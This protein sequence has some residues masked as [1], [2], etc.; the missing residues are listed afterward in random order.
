M[1]SNEPMWPKRHICVS[2]SEASGLTELKSDQEGE[3]HNQHF[4]HMGLKILFSHAELQTG[5][6]LPTQLILPYLS[7]SQF[8]FM[9]INSNKA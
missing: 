8:G 2:C 6:F 7:H 4:K 5:R 1:H 9:N 3:K